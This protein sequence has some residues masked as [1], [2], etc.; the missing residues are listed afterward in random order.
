MSQPK[1]CDGI[2]LEP[3]RMKKI[4]PEAPKSR[5]YV[6][7]SQRTAKKE[8]LTLSVDDMASATLFPTLNSMSP[9]TS[10]AT[11]TQI[12]TRL[13]KPLTEVVGDAIERE[14]KALED[15]IRQEKETDPRKMTDAQVLANGWNYL[16]PTVQEFCVVDTEYPWSPTTDWTTA[17]EFSPD[18]MEDSQKFLKYA[19]CMNEDGTPLERAS[20]KPTNPLVVVEK[21]SVTKKFWDAAR[22]TG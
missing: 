14:R 13:A 10:G 3:V 9:T 1:A 11:W 2:V 19:E 7:P 15:G 4:E 8:E 5:A 18:L 16:R 17:P 21:Q 22:K 6:P 20:R 12:R